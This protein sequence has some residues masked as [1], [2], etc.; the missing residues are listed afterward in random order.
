MPAKSI[1][2]SEY[3]V[4]LRRLRALRTDAGLTQTE[5]SAA[6][7]RPQSY[8]SDVERG[9]RR[10]DL[11]Q[12]REFCNACGQSLTEFVGEFEQELG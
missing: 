9:S 8:V 3:I 7:H 5:L 12:L 10:M 4:L 2:K 6:L 11:L 1:H